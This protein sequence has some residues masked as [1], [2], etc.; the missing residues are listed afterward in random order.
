[1]DDTTT[2]KI[3]EL[4]KDPEALGKIASI[5]SGLAGDRETPPQ[6]TAPSVRPSAPALPASNDKTA[7]LKALKPMLRDDKQQKID[8][9]INAL[10]VAAVVSSLK[11]DK[12][13]SYNVQQ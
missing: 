11:G 8:R 5:V 6:I 3:A 12:G 7:L 13:G 9:L 10:T 1:M 2:Q 4:L